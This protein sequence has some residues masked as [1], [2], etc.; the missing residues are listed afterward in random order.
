[1]DAPWWTIFILAVV[2]YTLWVSGAFKKKKTD[3]E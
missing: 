2:F 3:D 1:M